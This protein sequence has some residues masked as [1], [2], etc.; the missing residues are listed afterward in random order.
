V[1]GGYGDDLL[2]GGSGNDS[3]TGDIC[4]DGPVDPKGVDILF[5]G[6][7]RDYLEGQVMHGGPNT[8]RF[9]VFGR[10]RRRIYG[11]TGDDRV[12]FSRSPRTSTR[13][14]VRCGPGDG[15][16][17]IYLGRRDENDVLIDC[18]VIRPAS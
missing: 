3:M 5:G 10:D 2:F 12:T 16:R 15:D 8:D 14:V 17:V 7:G 4:F 9:Y 11:G 18:E 13:D 6:P 1:C